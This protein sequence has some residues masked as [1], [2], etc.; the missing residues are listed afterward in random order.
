[1][2]IE[3]AMRLLCFLIALSFSVFASNATTTPCREWLE[4]SVGVAAD[5]TWD[6]DIEL[7]EG[8]TDFL[9]RTLDLHQKDAHAAQLKGEGKVRSLL[10]AASDCFEEQ[11]EAADAAK[12]LILDVNRML[13]DTRNGE[14]RRLSLLVP[15]NTPA[16]S[17]GASVA[18][19]GG[20]CAL[21]A[22]ALGFVPPEVLIPA[23]PVL[24]WGLMHNADVSNTILRRHYMVRPP[25]SAP[26]SDRAW[27]LRNALHEGTSLE[28]P[29][30]ALRIGKGTV[31]FEV[32]RTPDSV[33]M[34]IV[35]IEPR[36]SLGSE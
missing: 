32:I 16:K 26:R 15:G 12:P 27:E 8:F 35:V 21:V 30:F 7:S 14:Y 36:E 9:V 10:Q 3:P 19:T 18:S 1:L 22:T 29:Q 2:V 33:S 17:I 31:A 6:D 11:R 5:L 20:A 25:P 34:Q 24:V 4:K 23:V 28:R 13:R